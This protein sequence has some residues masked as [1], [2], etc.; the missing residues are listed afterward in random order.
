MFMYFIL[1]ID[2]S[3][4]MMATGMYDTA[5]IYKVMAK[6]RR[7]E[8]ITIGVI[9][10]SITAGYAASTENKRWANLMTDWWKT[11]FTSSK[12]TLINAGFGGTGSAIAD[13][14]VQDELLKFK[15]DFV[16]IE[17]AVNDSLDNL[18][19]ETMEGLVR[20][21]LVSS[22]K[23]GVMMLNL[24]NKD[25]TSAI[26]YHKPIAEHYKIPFINFKAFIYPQ[27]TLDKRQLNNIYL[28]DVHPN[29]TGMNY[30][31]LF[32]KNELEKIYE[33]LPLDSNLPEKEYVLPSPYVS[34]V[35]VHTQKYTNETLIPVK[36]TGW[37]PSGSGW[38]SNKVDA[39][40]TFSVEG[41]A[42]GIIYN[43]H[44]ND[45]WGKAEFWVDDG[46]HKV[47]DAYWT[48]KWGPATVFSQIAG[49]LP[50]GKHALHMKISSEYTNGTGG[51]YFPIL[52]IL[53][54]GR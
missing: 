15:P 35:Y 21:I 18:S 13:F 32:L 44:D 39:E 6:A 30:I 47:I 17:F 43:L 38:S 12:V 3:I 23:P 50:E 1:Q 20:Q 36:N 24:M 28:D 25:G 5:R 2:L 16:V 52:N 42:I 53:K 29:D 41:D 46:P 40:M 27:L 45:T 8:P 10:G 14:R 19:A 26:D 49:N 37:L 7:G 54:A 31:A 9:G 11:K 34:D 22:N 51:H 4:D 33:N 48:Q